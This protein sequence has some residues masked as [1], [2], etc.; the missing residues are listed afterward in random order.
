MDIICIVVIK[1]GGVMLK[2]EPWHHLYEYNADIQVTHPAQCGA[3]GKC[4]LCGE[5]HE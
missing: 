5:S 2:H 1:H 3:R 4:S